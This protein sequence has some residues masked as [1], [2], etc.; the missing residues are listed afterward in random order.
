M[1][2]EDAGAIRA[3]IDALNQ[4]AMKLGQAMYAEQGGGPQGPSGGAA[5]AE[6]PVATGRGDGRLLRWRADQP[7]GCLDMDHWIVYADARNCTGYRR[8]SSC[9]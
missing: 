5:P 3:G 7:R 4:A 2:R 8:M 1:G 9:G 6:R